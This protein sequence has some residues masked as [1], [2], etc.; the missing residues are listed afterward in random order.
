MK[1]KKIISVCFSFA[2]ITAVVLACLY[3]SDSKADFP[4]CE[5]NTFNMGTIVS[6]K[7]YSENGENLC[8]GARDLIIDLENKIS[9]KKDDTALSLL[10]EKGEVKDS[11]VYN[12]LLS[13]EKLRE[14]SDGAFNIKVGKLI[15]LWA[16][17]EGNE[18]LPEKEELTSLLNEAKESELTFLSDGVTVKLDGNAEIDLGAVGKGLA[19]DRAIAFYKTSKNCK[20]AIISVGGSI[21]CFGSRNKAGDKWKIAVRHPRKENE[22]LGV[23]S[24]KEGF[25]STS[26]DYEKFFTLD[27]ERY[28]HILDGNT[29]YPSKSGVISV[30]VV[31]DNGFLSDALSTACLILGREKSEP[32][33]KEFNASAVFVSEEMEITTVGEVEFEKQN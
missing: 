21:G 15:D 13:C 20:G 9:R 14:K 22:F 26:G 2:V 27:G 30:T 31:C 1:K 8:D 28:H 3:Y 29:G 7:V 24:L 19:C 4:L 16:I 12:L 10:N 18:A 17:D 23:V 32:L 5:K 11:E 33:L 25:V 6:Q